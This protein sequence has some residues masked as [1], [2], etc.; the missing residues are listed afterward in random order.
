ME[1]RCI[2]TGT[3]GSTTRG[4]QSILV[5]DILFD[6]GSGVVKKIEAMQIYT[7]SIKYLVI[8]HVH[9]D[10]FVDLPNYLIGRSI[11][12]ENSQTLPIICGKGVK[13]KAIK[14]FELCFG[15]GNKDK[16]NN[17][18]EKYNVQFIEL[19]DGQSY[20]NNRIKLTAYDLEHGGCK[21][22]LG[23]T[24]EKE[25]KVVGYATDTTL[26]ENVEKICQKC[27]IA[28][29][30]A[31]NTIPTKSHMGLDEVIELSK[32]YPKCKIYAVHRSDYVHSHIKEIN[33]PEDEQIIKL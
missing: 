28:F 13:E 32:K 21:P 16:Y 12:K 11:R 26:C 15:D 2:G 29:L 25:G 19:E 22:I 24:L 7:K 6:I 27:D 17:F 4:N 14:L 33:F 5:D 30:D 10:H 20:S 3:M 31:T 9:A 18:E 8:T 1:I 23:Y